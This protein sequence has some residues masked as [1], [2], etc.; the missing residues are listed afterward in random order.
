M[1]NNRNKKKKKKKNKKETAKKNSAPPRH[2]FYL[3]TQFP[4]VGYPSSVV[5]LVNYTRKVYIFSPLNISS[6]SYQTM[7]NYILHPIHKLINV[8]SID[9]SF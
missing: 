9:N 5:H 8:H 6:V 1:Q 3:N 2:Q 7:T 4:G